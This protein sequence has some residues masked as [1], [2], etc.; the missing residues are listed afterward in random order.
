MVLILKKLFESKYKMVAH[1]KKIREA[2]LGNTVE[3]ISICTELYRFYGLGTTG[4]FL[5][6][7]VGNFTSNMMWIRWCV[8]HE[9][10]SYF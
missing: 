8:F 4:I 6:K 2:E 1:K 5:Q 3:K 9:R 10:C 7:I